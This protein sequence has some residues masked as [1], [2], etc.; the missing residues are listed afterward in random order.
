L[1]VDTPAAY[2]QEIGG[3]R[4]PVDVGDAPRRL[5]RFAEAAGRE[6]TGE[7]PSQDGVE[8]GLPGHAQVEGLEPPGGPE[9]QRR[10]VAAAVL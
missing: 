3:R 10:R 9:Q 5:R 6:A 4:G 1:S 7:V 2:P 8:V